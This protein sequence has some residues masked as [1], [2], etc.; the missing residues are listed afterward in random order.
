[1]Q[2]VYEQAVAVA[3]ALVAGAHCV[4]Q[5]QQQ[6][7]GKAALLALT[8]GSPHNDKQCGYV[9]IALC[10]AAGCFAEPQD[11]IANLLA[12]AAGAA[13]RVTVQHAHGHNGVSSG[14]AGATMGM[15]CC[16]PLA[17]MSQRGAAV[18]LSWACW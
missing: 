4:Q 12:A 17:H 6:T 15:A 2:Q 8:Q 13:A 5:E 16:K 10:A 18:V 1:M 14:I 11:C 3:A 9:M 7:C